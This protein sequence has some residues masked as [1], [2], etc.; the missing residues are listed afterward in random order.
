MDKG[1]AFRYQEDR[2]SR[3]KGIEEQGELVSVVI[4]VYK[5]EAYLEECLDSVLRQT[6]ENIEVLLVDDGSPD[7]CP[8][9]CDSYARTDPR[10]RVIHTKNRGLSA[11]RNIALDHASG[12]C[13]FCL[14]S[15]DYLAPEALEKLCLARREQH[16]QIAICAHYMIRGDRITMEDPVEDRVEVMGRFDALSALIE[17]REIRSYAWG[18]LVDRELYEGVR[19]PEGRIYEDIAT[20]YRLF[21]KAERIVHIP[22]HLLYY[23]IRSNSI[24]GKES[25]EKWHENNHA[26]VLSMIERR[27]FLRD[28]HEE[29]LA[30]R[31]M[32]KLIPYLYSDIRTAYLVGKRE[33]AS[34]A[35]NYLRLNREAIMADRNISSKDKRIFHLYLQGPATFRVFLRT[36]DLVNA[37]CSVEA[38][39]AAKISMGRLPF[40]LEKGKTRRLVYFELPCFD[41]LG[42]HAIRYATEKYLK[43]YAKRD[44]KAQ[45][46]TVGGWDT[47]PGIRS[48]RRV[49]GPEDII[50]LQGGGN[51]GSMYDFAEIFRRKVIRS[52]RNNRIIILPQTVYYAKDEGGDEELKEDRKVF[53]RCRDLTICARDRQSEDFLRKNF[54]AR[55]IP[56]KDMVLSLGNVAEEKGMRHGILLA[57][58]SDREGR[59][60][61]ADKEKIIRICRTFTDD[62]FVTDTCV[63]RELKEAEAENLLKNKW[64]LFSG[65]KLIVTDRLHGMLFAV[66]TRTP[67]VVIGGSHF[68]IRETFRTVRDCGYVFFLDNEKKLAKVIEEALMEEGRERILPDYRGDFLELEQ[69]LRGTDVGALTAG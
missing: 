18:K 40:D 53:G 38:R 12:D 11:A 46:F 1:G 66:I 28:K 26:M 41:N 23:R 2:K 4:P 29:E 35:Q 44:G 30:G 52:F 42:D 49:S 10:I 69:L 43:E 24:S 54:S 13:I 58:R 19:Y 32:E 27:D 67:C 57:L 3:S 55:V 51:L 21:D 60:T 15:D 39:M 31:A 59:L 65:R 48:L 17:D 47:V 22:D 6:W 8:G 9:I 63:H 14:D 25:L 68:K 56:M 7:R 33:D 20:T 45:V 37:V 34:L 61:G 5:V 50:I 36:K 64:R 16:A 62:V